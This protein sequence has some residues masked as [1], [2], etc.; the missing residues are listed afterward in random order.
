MFRF[1]ENLKNIQERKKYNHNLCSKKKAIVGTDSVITQ[2]L[3]LSNKE[4][5]ANKM[6]HDVSNMVE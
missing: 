5:K 6:R 3:E 4:I 1:K 2:K